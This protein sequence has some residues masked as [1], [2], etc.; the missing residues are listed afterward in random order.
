MTRIDRFHTNAR[1]V[2]R[3]LGIVLGLV[4]IRSFP[5]DERDR[6][7]D[8][9]KRIPRIDIAELGHRCAGRLG[10]GVVLISVPRQDDPAISLSHCTLPPHLFTQKHRPHIL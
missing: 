7:I 4:S 2:P 10:L 5:P 8:L 6:A 1:E 3:Y 9:T